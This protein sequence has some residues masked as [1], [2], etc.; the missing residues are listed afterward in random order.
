MEASHE[1][2]KKGLF[3][4]CLADKK[5]QVKRDTLHSLRF[6]S[7]QCFELLYQ[8]CSTSIEAGGAFNSKQEDEATAVLMVDEDNATTSATVSSLLR[9]YNDQIVNFFNNLVVK[10]VKPNVCDE[11]CHAMTEVLTSTETLLNTSLLDQRDK[12]IVSCVVNKMKIPLKSSQS[13]Y[14]RKKRLHNQDYFIKPM[15]V[16]LSTQFSLKRKYSTRD[17]QSETADFMFVPPSSIIRTLW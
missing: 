14:K 2:P 1:T 4:S 8:G 11:V 13:D 12:A 5:C 3:L 10:G 7:K 9:V 15:P 16:A 17:R 6:H